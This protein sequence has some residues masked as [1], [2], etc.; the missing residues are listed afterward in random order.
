VSIFLRIPGISG[1]VSDASHGQWI[2]GDTLQWQ[3]HRRITSATGTQ[4]DRESANTEF[5]ELQI[6]RR[7]DA[8]TPY[9]FIETCCGT[10]KTINIHLCKTGTGTA[11]NVFM[12][13]T[14]HHA[15]L[16]DY[17]VINSGFGNNRPIE[18]LSISFSGM[19][20]KYTPYD[21]NG[22]AMS[23]IAVGFDITTTEWETFAQAVRGIPD[24][25]RNRIEMEAAQQ[26]WAHETDY[27]QKQFWM[28]IYHGCQV[29]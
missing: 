18:R 2:D 23:P 27:K 13:Y 10:G 20:T 17:R 4:G 6:L 25:K 19:E 1:E 29:E 7:M 26:V 21:Q 8:A 5:S 28:A 16:S 12:A 9:L 11:A 24:M 15:L 3:N 14:L 22:D